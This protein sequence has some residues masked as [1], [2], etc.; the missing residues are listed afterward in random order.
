MVKELLYPFDG[1]VE[2]SVSL[3]DKTA[4]VTHRANVEPEEIVRVI[5]T[6]HLGASLKE[7]GAAAIAGGVLRSAAH[8]TAV[9]C[10]IQAVLFTLGALFMFAVGKCH[11]SEHCNDVYAGGFNG[12]EIAANGLWGCCLPL[13]YKLF[14]HAAL[15][16]MR[17]RPNMEVLMSIAVLGSVG[18]GDLM[19]AALV[20]IIVKL[21]ELVTD[22]AIQYI[23]QKLKGMV[24]STPEMV[25]L[26]TGAT[27]AVSD[28][29]PGAEIVVLLIIIYNRDCCTDEQLTQYLLFIIYNRDCSMDDSCSTLSMHV[30]AGRRVSAGG[31][32][33]DCR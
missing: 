7:T 22:C 27:V 11:D 21:L 26:T 14:H 5:N 17:L 19:T 29:M 33:S 25:S 23:D 8:S 9:V 18:L 6:K 20:A 31:R 13:S 10:T 4:F 2:V 16:C 3:V 30:G 24:V 28:V 15:A 12:W 32:Y 1:I